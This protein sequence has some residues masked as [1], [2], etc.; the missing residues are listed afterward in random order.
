MAPSGEGPSRVR[1]ISKWE[2]IIGQATSRDKLGPE[3]Q[4]TRRV[5]LKAMDE[6]LLIHQIGRTDLK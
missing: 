4:Y 6:Y 2:F 1:I 3:E 5:F